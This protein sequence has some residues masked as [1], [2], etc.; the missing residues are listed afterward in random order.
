[1]ARAGRAWQKGSESGGCEYLGVYAV[2]VLSGTKGQPNYDAQ[3]EAAL[4]YGTNALDNKHTAPT[5]EKP[6][7]HATGRN[8]QRVPPTP[9]ATPSK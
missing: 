3:Y 7:T 4:A 9:A 1:V 6:P 8:P 5:A 2:D